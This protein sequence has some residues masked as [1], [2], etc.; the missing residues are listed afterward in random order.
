MYTYCLNNPIA[1]SDHTG[2]SATIAGAICGAF[3]GALNAVISGGDFEEIVQCTLV[4]MATGAA[5]GFVADL[6]IATCGVGTA[7]LYSA[8][9]GGI[10]SATN[11]AASQYVLN[12]GQIDPA[13]VAYDGIIGAAAGG[14]STA[15]GDLVK[16]VAKGLVNGINHVNTLIST[17]IIMTTSGTITTSYLFDI[18]CSAV[19]GFG[20]WLFGSACD[21]YNSMG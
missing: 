16:P 13:K 4:G 10:M 11:S 2:E 19:T 17:E 15:M 9:A 14:A 8:V 1:Y 18:G 5:A 20:A 3:F 7:I 12:D 6:S 21:Y